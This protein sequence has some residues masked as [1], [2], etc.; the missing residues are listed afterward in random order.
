VSPDVKV[1]ERP[2]QSVRPEVSRACRH[3]AASAPG[4]HHG[5][6][7]PTTRNILVIPATHINLVIPAN[8]GIQSLLWRDVQGWTGE[9][10]LEDYK[11]SEECCA[12]A[13]PAPICLRHLPA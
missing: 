4:I 12:F 6:L 9:P 8:A 5:V 10:S 7:D 13:A 1:T 2:L 11:A 3:D